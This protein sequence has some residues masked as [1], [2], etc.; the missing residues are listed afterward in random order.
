MELDKKRT[1]LLICVVYTLLTLI[2]S[3]YGLAAGRTMDTHAHIL[4]RFVVT[5]LG[6]GSLHLFRLVPR[7]PLP[8]AVAFHYGATM[9]AIWLLV[10]ISGRFLTLHP[11]ACRDIFLNYSAIYLLASA[12]FLG[13]RKRRRG[14]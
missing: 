10:W 11:D 3:G 12:G 5:V 8:G 7:W 13:I 2:S 14:A 6:I 1:V 9:G 4:L